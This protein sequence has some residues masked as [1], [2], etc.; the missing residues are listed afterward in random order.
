MP[1]SGTFLA[2]RDIERFL[3]PYPEDMKEIVLELRSL[4]ARIEPGA[5]ER[6]LWGGLSYHHP[7]RGG[8]VKAGICQIEPHPDH[9][10]LGFVHGAFLPDPG[11]LLKG[12]RLAKRF[13]ELKTYD[14]VPWLHVA[15]FIQAAADY[16]PG[17]DAT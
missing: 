6:I 4:V 8:P 1:S 2:N 16:R 11:N 17:K 3:L 15:E 10:R 9:V 14:A 13:A 7:A 12:D 5:A